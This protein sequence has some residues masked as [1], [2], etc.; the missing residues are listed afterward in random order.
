MQELEKSS[1]EICSFV[2]QNQSE[3]GQGDSIAVP[4]CKIKY[5]IFK[6]MSPIE[7]NRLKKEFLNLCKM[8]PPKTKEVF[9]DS[10]V[11]FVNS[12]VDSD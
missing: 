11:E 3:F 5:R 10:F 8:K 12:S 2:V 9:G 6:V 7:L 4:N 1:K